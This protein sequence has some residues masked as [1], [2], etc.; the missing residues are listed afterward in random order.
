MRTTSAERMRALRARR[1]R[2]KVYLEVDLHA[3]DLREI[4]LLRVLSETELLQPISD[5]LHRGSAQDYS[6][7]VR[8]HRPDYLTNPQRS[9]RIRALAD[10]G[11]PFKSF[12]IPLP[13]LARAAHA[14]GPMTGSPKIVLAETALAAFAGAN[15]CRKGTAPLRLTPLNASRAR[16]STRYGQAALDP[17]PLR[18][19]HHLH[20]EDRPELRQLALDPLQ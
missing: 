11:G 14:P 10:C 9:R 20:V 13:A 6:G 16:R 18:L 8:P 19:A 5:L 15:T 17:R 12:A 4:A 2:G 3:D 1:R 7:F